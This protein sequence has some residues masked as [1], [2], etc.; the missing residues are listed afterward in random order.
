M[1]VQPTAFVLSMANSEG[2]FTAAAAGCLL[3]LHRRRWLVAGLCGAAASLTRPSGVVLAVACA[4]AAV[5]VAVRTRRPGPLVAPLVAPLGIL[6]FFTFLAVRTGRW[7]A[8]FV[9][10]N[11]GWGAHTDFGYDTTRRLIRSVVHPF[12]KP[13]GVAVIAAVVV[14]AVLIVWLLRDRRSGRL[15]APPEALVTGVG[16]ALL[17]VSTSN[18]FSSIPGSSCPPSPCCRRWPAACGGCRS[19]CSRFSWWPRPPYR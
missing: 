4:V 18:V 16:F 9:T 11:Q 3:A 17:A 19:G 1:A 6:G 5:P 7:D 8:W 2:L 12:A 10:E 14:S 15:P 13:A